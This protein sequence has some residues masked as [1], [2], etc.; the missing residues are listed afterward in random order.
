MGKREQHFQ[1]I[2]KYKEKFRHLSTEMIRYRLSNFETAFFPEA[3]IA[4]RQLLEE[5]EQ[6]GADPEIN[7]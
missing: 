4:L 2:A 6:Q 7:S 1:E 5:R 3:R